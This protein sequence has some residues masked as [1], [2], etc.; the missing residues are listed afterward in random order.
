MSRRVRIA[1]AA[2]V[3]A[4]GCVAIAQADGPPQGI[5]RPTQEPAQPSLQLG[6]QLYAGNC[7]SC[8]GIAGSGITHPRPGSGNIEGQGPSLRGV[9]EQASDF[10]LRVGFM[11]LA[12]PREEPQN[13][14][15]W[16]N[17][18]E[19]RSLNMYVA[20]L[21]RGPSIP[22]VDASAGSIT[23]GLKLFTDRCAGCHQMVGR[24]G[25]VYGA[26]VPPL[27]GYTPTE[28]AEAVR[29]GP[30]LMPKFSAKD[31]SDSQ[32]NSLV[33]YVLDTA[34]PD[35]HGGWGIGNLG[36]IPEGMV[37]AWIAIPLVLLSCLAV[38][39]RLGK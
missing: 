39:R 11:P 18:K 17:D 26:R 1:L 29:I 36:P 21:G 35:N 9:G 34:N 31:I 27:Q 32:L 5:V 30:Y 10:Y 37:I 13:N 19:I 33:R 22:Q 25:Y 6:A 28:I 24:G 8:H 20:S 23:E 7:A 14:R 3:W 16:F 12:H 38:S 2:L 4:L 15:V